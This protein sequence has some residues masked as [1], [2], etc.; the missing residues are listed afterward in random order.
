MGAGFHKGMGSRRSIQWES[1]V[2]DG[3]DFAGGD[4]GQNIGFDCP[5]DSAFVGYRPRTQG[6]AGMVQPLEHDATKIDCRLWTSLKRDLHDAYLNRRGFV[7]PRDV[8]PAHHVHYN[9]GA[10]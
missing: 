5:R 4:K 10:L 9:L 7:V 2:D 3:F 6:R 1:L 8:V